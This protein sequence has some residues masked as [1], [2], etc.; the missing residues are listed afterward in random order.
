M[1][2]IILQQKGQTSVY[3]AIHTPPKIKL[4]DFGIAGLANNFNVDKIDVGSLRYMAPETFRNAKIGPS[5][6]V[7]ALGVILYGL[8]TGN[9]PFKGSSCQEIKL[10]IM[11]ANYQLPTNIEF[12][13]EYRDLISRIFIIDPLKRIKVNDIL[14]HAWMVKENSVHSTMLSEIKSTKQLHIAREV[15]VKF[16]DGTNILMYEEIQPV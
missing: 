5:I 2:N 15:T 13:V 1:E 8:T 11:T 6:D 14:S 9:L 12:S 10:Q 7:W 3:Y 4:I 16:V